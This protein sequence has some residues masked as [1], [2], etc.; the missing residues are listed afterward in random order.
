M[1]RESNDLKRTRLLLADDHAIVLEAFK[2]LLEPFHLVVAAVTDGRQLLAK[3][4][5]LRPDIVLVDINMP[6]LNGLDAC[7]QLVSRNPETKVIFLTVSEDVDSAEEAIRRGASG[8]LIKKAVVGELYKAIET[9]SRG[10]IY[11]TPLVST[12]PVN[13]FVARAKRRET[14]QPLTE[15][16][17]EVLHLLA[18]GKSMKEAAG[19]LG[20]TPRTIAFH[21]YAMMEHLGFARNSELVC[22]A[23]T[24]LFRNAGA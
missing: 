19:I 4:R 1:R 20:I 24:E 17:R 23:Q 10:G 13:V 7:E 5:E 9:V 11:I 8:Y 15:R 21:K 22:Y 12:L 16:Q 6:G 14:R 2:K 3:A 18:E